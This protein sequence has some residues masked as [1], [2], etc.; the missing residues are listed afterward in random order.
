MFVYNEKTAT[1]TLQ[2][3]NIQYLKVFS[4]NSVFNITVYC[5]NIL[6][7]FKNAILITVCETYIVNFNRK[8]L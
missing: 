6:Y 1:E 4:E 3:S 2:R 7:F 5:F 8:K